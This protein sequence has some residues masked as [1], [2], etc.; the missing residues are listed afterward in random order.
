MTVS[1]HFPLKGSPVKVTAVKRELTTFEDE[2]NKF[3]TTKKKRRSVVKH[4]KLESDKID[5][6][7]NFWPMYEEIKKMRKIIKTPVDV[8]GCAKIPQILE[9]ITKVYKET[10]KINELSM[11]DIKNLNG[12]TRGDALNEYQPERET[13]K[14]F[15]FQMFTSLL[16]SSQTKDEVNFQVM[17]RL[18]CKYLPKYEGGLCCEAIENED[19][20]ELDKLIN[21]IGFHS[22][23]TQYLKLASNRII[24]EYQGDIPDTLDD[25]I[26]FKGI[27]FKMG[28]LIMMGAWGKIEGI[29]VDTHMARMCGLYNWIPIKGVREKMDPEYV[30]KSL[31]EMLRN[32]KEIWSEIN[33]VLVG[34]GQSVCTP[35]SRRCDLCWLRGKEFNDSGIECPSVDKRLLIRVKRGT[36]SDRKIRGDLDSLIEMAPRKAKQGKAENEEVELF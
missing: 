25:L 4:V 31:E 10:G 14:E 19:P 34:F 24:N 6:P 28:I 17:Q 21:P 3:N 9:S 36:D 12:S 15:R 11:D 30:R 1:K 29:S 23:K 2:I 20:I 35:V 27:G 8:F 33:P 5:P 7:E 18:H 16:F 22:R 26:D 32:H 13:S